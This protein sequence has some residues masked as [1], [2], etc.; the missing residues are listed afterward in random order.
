MAF[1][2]WSRWTCLGS[3]PTWSA[4]SVTPALLIPKVLDVTT[5]Y[6]R[7]FHNNDKSDPLL[8]ETGQHI[9]HLPQRHIQHHHQR[10]AQGEE[11]GAHVGMLALAH[12]GDQLLHHHI[13]H[14]AGS[15]GQ[16]KG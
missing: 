4:G 10:E 1:G 6:A 2:G 11:D 16:H 9:L 15:K 8:R 13:Q 3:Y 12:F 5:Y 14:G 7:I